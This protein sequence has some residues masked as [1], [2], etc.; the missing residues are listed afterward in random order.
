MKALTKRM[1]C[2]SLKFFFPSMTKIR[3][4]KV[5]PNLYRNHL[6]MADI[7]KLNKYQTFG[8]MK[9]YKMS[10]IWFAYNNFS[11]WKSLLFDKLGVKNF[12]FKIG[13]FLF[14]QVL[15]LLWTIFK[16]FLE[17]PSFSMMD[18]ESSAISQMLFIYRSLTMKRRFF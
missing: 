3:L 15:K 12:V 16:N 7:F 4:F 9:M 14:F 1:C 17:N 2:K 13:A 10:K 11:L 5:F 18:F 8:L 6:L